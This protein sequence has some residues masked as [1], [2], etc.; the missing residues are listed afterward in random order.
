M[1]LRKHFKTSNKLETEGIWLEL[2][3]TRI[4]VARAGGTNQKYNAAMERVSKEH[5]RAIANE[6]LTSQQS[7]TIL[8]EAYI[9]TVIK[10]WQTN[11][12]PEGSIEEDWQDGIEA[13][14]G[15]ELLPFT[16]DNVRATLIELPDLFMEIKE[17]A[18]KLHYF[19]Q[20]RLDAA[21]KN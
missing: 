17:A 5:K 14:D 2:G 11:V 6:L 16:P 13:D 7:L 21:V 12:A 4:R 18:E 10:A 20:S 3:T 1:S 9:E 8:R 19:Q 15:G